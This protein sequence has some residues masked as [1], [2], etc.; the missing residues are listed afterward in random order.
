MDRDMDQ[1]ESQDEGQHDGWL[2]RDGRGRDG[3]QLRTEQVP[4]R[5]GKYIKNE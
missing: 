3:R 5:V 1:E 2:Y 4:S